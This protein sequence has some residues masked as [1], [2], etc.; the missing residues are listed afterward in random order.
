M[1]GE[2]RRVSIAEA[3]LDVEKRMPSLMANALPMGIGA[4]NESM[5]S[6]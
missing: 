2:R 4:V 5:W 1:G 6:I 3:V